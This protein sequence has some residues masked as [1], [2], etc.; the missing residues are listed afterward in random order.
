MNSKSIENM[1][2]N[3]YYNL[4]ID[5]LKEDYSNFISETI[6]S[7]CEDADKYVESLK[8]KT[9][10][11]VDN[12]DKYEDEVLEYNIIKLLRQS[13]NTDDV[14]RKY[15][16]RMYDA[17]FERFKEIVERRSNKYKSAKLCD[18]EMKA[19]MYVRQSSMVESVDEFTDFYDDAI[20]DAI[21][22]TIDCSEFNKT[23]CCDDSV[24]EALETSDKKLKS[25]PN[26]SNVKYVDFKDLIKLAESNDYFYE[27]S[28]G[29]HRIY[30][31]NSTGK[32]VVIPYHNLGQGLSFAIQKQIKLNSV[33]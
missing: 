31:H 8:Q 18:R 4:T 21:M 28:N 24:E 11:Y 19:L 17:V 7:V 15:L 1:I 29:D 13:V 2:D 32:I 16:D 26:Q 6:V 22:N 20:Y 30:K 3:Y 33:A 27:R 12:Y 25:I 14:I 5:E 23:L 10:M 9:H